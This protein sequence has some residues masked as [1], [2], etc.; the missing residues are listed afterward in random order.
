M[1]RKCWK[2]RAGR[3]ISRII[4]RHKAVECFLKDEAVTAFYGFSGGGINMVHVLDR[5]AS[6][7][8][9][10]LHRVELVVVLGAPEVPQE[11]YE[12]SKYNEPLKKYNKSLKDPKK[13]VPLARWHLEYRTN[14]V[15]KTNP[16][17]Y[18]EVVPKMPKGKEPLN[19]HMFG[20]EWLLSDTP[21]NKTP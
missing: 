1:I 2:F 21:P 9:D 17:K 20:P 6:K 18:D 13:E 12:L 11:E 10:T 16:K 7:N 3:I 15:Y 8:R 19:S 5:L 4:R 14:L